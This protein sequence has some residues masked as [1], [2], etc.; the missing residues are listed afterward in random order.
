[1]GRDSHRYQVQNTSIPFKPMTL[2]RQ[3]CRIARHSVAEVAHRPLPLANVHQVVL[4]PHLPRTE[5]SIARIPQ[6][7]QYVS[8]VA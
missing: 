5:Q 1:M 7:R 6:S 3:N 4:L 8:V 2:H